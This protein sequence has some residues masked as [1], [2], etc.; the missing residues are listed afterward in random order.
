MHIL[1]NLALLAMP[2]SIFQLSRGKVIW[3]TQTQLLKLLQ[4]V[5]C[6]R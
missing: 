1:E 2:V 5:Q 4:V 6:L 3:V